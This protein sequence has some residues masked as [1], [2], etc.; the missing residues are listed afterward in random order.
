MKNEKLE[1]MNIEDESIYPTQTLGDARKCWAVY[2]FY[3]QG[4]HSPMLCHIA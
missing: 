4:S 3:E 1:K 2:A